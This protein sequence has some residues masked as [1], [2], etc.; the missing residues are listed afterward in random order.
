MPTCWNV[1][2]SAWYSINLRGSNELVSIDRV[3]RIIVKFYKE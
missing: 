2:V 1:L 3:I